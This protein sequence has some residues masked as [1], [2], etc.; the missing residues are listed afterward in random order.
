MQVTYW[1][2]NRQQ[3]RDGSKVHFK[4]PPNVCARLVYGY[5]WRAALTYLLV[6]DLTAY[7]P[8][9]ISVSQSGSL[10]SL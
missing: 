6:Y 7:T 8:R 3:R 9:S 1:T 4:L 5:K 10:P 2:R